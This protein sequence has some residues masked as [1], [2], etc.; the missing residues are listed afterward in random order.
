MNKVQMFSS[1]CN[2]CP[3]QNHW[4]VARNMMTMLIHIYMC[5]NAYSDVATFLFFSWILISRDVQKIA[6]I[7]NL[8]NVFTC[9]FHLD[10]WFFFSVILHIQK[11]CNFV[12]ISLYYRELK[13]NFKNGNTFLIDRKITNSMFLK[14]SCQIFNEG[15]FIHP[16]TFIL[17]FAFISPL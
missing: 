2:V 3:N 14:N 9:Y 12:C 8:S 5:T 7:P 15:R 10:I 16:T 11:N 13:T 1:L 6:Y 17:S 4:R